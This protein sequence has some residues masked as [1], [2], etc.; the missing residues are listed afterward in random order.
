MKVIRSLARWP[1]F[2]AS[3][4]V[5]VFLVA[6]FV[7]GAQPSVSALLGYVGT[8]AFVAVF[9]A[10]GSR[11]ESS[12]R[13]DQLSNEIEALA[14]SV[15]TGA[16][17]PLRT[18]DDVFRALIE[19]RSR[20]SS[21]IRLMKVRRKCPL[22]YDEGSGSFEHGEDGKPR[23]R[24]AGEDIRTWYEGLPQWAAETGHRAER[25]ISV[26]GRDGEPLAE[27]KAYADFAEEQMAARNAD[28]APCP[29]QWDFSKPVLNLCIFDEDEA[30]VT[31]FAE[32]IRD[33]FRQMT[34]IRIVHGPTVRWLT[35]KYYERM[36]KG[37]AV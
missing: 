16:I 36:K 30:I 19:A 24:K 11:E 15:R 18:P 6:E 9:Q 22:V 14:Q 26:S 35:H 3:V 10:F 33:E 5:L 4:G 7:L 31:L 13:F 20:A 8:L 12:V 21:E 17:Y 37:A 32:D 27:M 28:F 25:V 23:Y 34:G 29:I 1:A 2:V